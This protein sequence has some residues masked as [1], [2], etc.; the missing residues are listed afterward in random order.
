MTYVEHLKSSMPVG[1]RLVVLDLL[2]GGADA[3]FAAI[4]RLAA[5]PER[6]WAA[7]LLAELL[8]SVERNEDLRRALTS[9]LRDSLGLSRPRLLLVRDAPL[10]TKL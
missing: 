1:P 10:T 8:A 3:H 6:R 9:D 5:D 4:E 2:E 7:P